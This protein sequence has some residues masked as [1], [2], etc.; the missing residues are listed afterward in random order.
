MDRELPAISANGT[1]VSANGQS[2]SGTSFAAPAVAGAAATI[3]QANPVLKSW[4]EGARAILLAAAGR[5]VSGTQWFQDVTNAVDA[6]DGSGALQNEI[7]RFISTSFVKPFAGTGPNLNGWCSG[8]LNAKNSFYNNGSAQDRWFFSIPRTNDRFKFR[9]VKIALAWNAKYVTYYSPVFPNTPISSA[10]TLTMD[11]DI[12][13]YDN[14]DNQKLVAHSS[15]FDN[16]YE[17]AEF[18]ALEGHEYRI[19]L[20]R[21]SAASVEEN[22]WFGLAWRVYTVGA[23]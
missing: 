20:Q 11:L 7:A 22:T 23:E 5:R 1:N 3:Q 6:V 14:T 19:E 9:N 15:I 16:S 8:N 13:V 12:Y 4:P 2:Q 10:S 21:H 18:S 17:I